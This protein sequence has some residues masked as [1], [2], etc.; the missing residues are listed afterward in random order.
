L[1]FKDNYFDA[2]KSKRERLAFTNDV[3]YKNLMIV[4]EGCDSCFGL[5]AIC[6][7]PIK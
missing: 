5:L 2:R 3:S 6:K 4:K 7:K 1:K